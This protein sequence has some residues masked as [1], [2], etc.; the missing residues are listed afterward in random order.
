MAGPLHFKGEDKVWVCIFTYAVYRAVYLE[1]VLSLST[2]RFMQ[3][4]RRFVARRTRPRMM[5]SDNGTNFVGAKDALSQKPRDAA[6]CM[7]IQTPK[8]TVVGR[9]LGTNDQYYG[10]KVLGL[11]CLNYDDLMTVICDCEAVINS[12]PITY[13]SD[14]PKELIAITPAMFLVDQPGSG[15]PDFDVVD[16]SSLC[17]KLRINKNYATI[18]VTYFGLGSC[19]DK[20]SS[21]PVKLGEIVLIGNDQDRRL[22]WLLGNVVEVLPAPIIAVPRVEEGAK[23]SAIVLKADIASF[24]VAVYQVSNGHIEA[25][26]GYDVSPE[27]VLF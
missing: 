20:K 6:Y 25:D 17:R 13:E 1:L 5:Y 4:F 18:C 21:R 11:A 12:R 9:I 27:F 10:T 14:D 26:D 8:R 15:L 23:F 19:R 7:A 16:R 22:D 2:H 24:F 3:A